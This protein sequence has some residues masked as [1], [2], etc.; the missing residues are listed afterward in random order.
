MPVARDP[1]SLP[2]TASDRSVTRRVLR[3]AVRL[4]AVLVHILAAI[5]C[6]L[7]VGSSWGRRPRAN[8]SSLA[9]ELTCWWSATLIRRFGLRIERRGTPLAGAVM[10]VANHVSWLDIVLINSQRATG[11]VAKSEIARWPVVGWLAGHAGTIYHQRGNTDSLV[12]VMQQMV[13]RLR[14]GAAVGVFPEGG[15]GDGTRVRTFHARIFQAALDAEA[16]V[17]PVALCYGRDGIQDQRIAF[18]RGE[19]FFPNFFRLL[20]SPPMTAS[21][22]FLAPVAVDSRR[23]MAQASRAGIAKALGHDDA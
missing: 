9:Q 4:P 1:H 21:I 12:T 16:Q 13:Q 7:I 6:A 8:G 17:Q 10:L 19:G 15:T 20:G 5:P 23:Q 18:S 2:P 3:Y 14:A 22:E 11:F